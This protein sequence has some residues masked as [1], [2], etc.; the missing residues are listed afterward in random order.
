M[1]RAVRPPAPRRRFPQPP[2][3]RPPAARRWGRGG[4]QPSSGSS[5][6]TSATAAS[7]SATVTSPPPPGASVD[8][9]GVN[10]PGC[11]SAEP[12]VVLLHGT[13]STIAVD[14]PVLVAALTAA[15]RCVYGQN[16]GF[17]G[18]GPVRDSAEATAAEI[19]SVLA[20]TGA[21]Q[22]DV[23]GFSQGGLVLRT[24][25]RFD[26]VSDL[27]RTA[28]LIS[29][30]FHGTTSPLIDSLPGNVCGA[31]ADQ[32]AGSALLTELAAGGDL[33]GAVRYATA[34]VSTDVIVT[35]WQQPAARRSGRAGPLRRAGPAL[36]G[37]L[38]AASGHGAG[39]GGRGLGD[40]CAGA[41]RGCGGRR[42]GVS[43]RSP[44]PG[45][46]SAD[47]ARCRAPVR[48]RATLNACAANLSR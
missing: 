27:V 15:G 44:T 33:D 38:R 4:A 29:P 45:R 37:H 35:P 48:S 32:K 40:P 9:A 28:A 17:Y 30:S 18:S 2:Q 6:A 3:C 14:F 12:P 26:G 31:C 43:L 11:V 42:L 13:F 8:L 7:T 23:V 5:S 25:L 1:P 22:V 21:T 10:D 24:A 47:R 41:R 36:P 16:Y 34:V 19:R 20:D 46:G 39:A